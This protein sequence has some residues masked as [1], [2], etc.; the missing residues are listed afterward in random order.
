M[1]AVAMTK[2]VAC[3]AMAMAGTIATHHSR[4]RHHSSATAMTQTPMTISVLPTWDQ[5]IVMVF[6]RA[7]RSRARSAFR[8]LSVWFSDFSGPRSSSPKPTM[9]SQTTK[10]G[11]IARRQ[12]T[13]GR[14]R[15]GGP[16]RTVDQ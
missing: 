15:R 8:P 14:L 13:A 11:R 5:T 9:A 16:G 1:I 2:M 4:V 3:R 7:V 12:E 6:H 10:P